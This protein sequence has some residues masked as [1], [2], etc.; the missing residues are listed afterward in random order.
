MN[1]IDEEPSESRKWI[2]RIGIGAL[3]T[4]GIFG[5]ISA[6]YKR[7]AKNKVDDFRDKIK[8]RYEK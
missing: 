8:N 6:S 7:L 2:Y 3:I 1:N 4:V 5:L